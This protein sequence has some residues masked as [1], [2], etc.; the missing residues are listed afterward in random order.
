MWLPSQVEVVMSSHL[1][2]LQTKADKIGQIKC[3]FGRKMCVLSR[4]AIRTIAG[5]SMH[6]SGGSDQAFLLVLAVA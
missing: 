6:N 4:K 1:S 5:F 3:L 2:R